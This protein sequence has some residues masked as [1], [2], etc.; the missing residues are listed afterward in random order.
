MTK[1]SFFVEGQT[2]RVFVATLLHE[3]LKIGTARVMSFK[4]VGEVLNRIMDVGNKVE[5]EFLIQIYDV[6]NDERAV[7]KMLESAENMIN[8]HGFEFLFA[9]RDLNP[10]ANKN[11]FEAKTKEQF[12][13]YPF[14][15]KLKLILAVKEIEAW[16]LGDYKVFERINSLLTPEYIQAH[17]GYDIINSPPE[18][19]DTPALMVG[20]IL[21]LVGLKYRKK[22]MDSYKIVSRLD[23][24]FLCIEAINRMSS[25]RY[26]IDS[27]D[28][29]I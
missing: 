26:F 13:K 7:S 25:F 6:G 21:D 19:H 23:F 29:C 18:D 8:T 11:T 28:Q 9:L 1:I 10:E 20:K 5:P 16:F 4:L 12:A 15:D 22:E 17:L 24:D 3:Y 27:I 2:E 14:A